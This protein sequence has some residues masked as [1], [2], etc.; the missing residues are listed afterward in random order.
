MYSLVEQEAGK[1]EWGRLYILWRVLRKR[2]CREPW[3][4]DRSGGQMML[5]GDIG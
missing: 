3:K 4:C 1:A 5:F 2:Y